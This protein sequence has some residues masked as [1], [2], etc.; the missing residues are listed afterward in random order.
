M[1]LS[2][3]SDPQPPTSHLPP[4]KKISSRSSDELLTFLH[5][6][7]DIYNPPVRG[8]KRRRNSV[9]SQAPNHAND[10]AS[11]PFERTYAIRW[12]TA[13]I[14]QCEI[15]EIFE[16]EST[17]LIIQ[18]A[19]SLL[20]TC[21]G[22]AG[23]GVIRRTFAFSSSV[24]VKLTDVPLEN[25]DFHSVGAQTWGGA[26]VLAEAI[27][28]AGLRILELGAGTGLVSLAAAKM[29]QVWDTPVTIVST[30]FYPTVLANLQ[31]NID[32]NF[33]FSSPV[34]ARFL[35]WATFADDVAEDAMLHQPFDVV[36]GADIVYEAQHA[37]WIKSCLRRLLTPELGI[38]HLVIP[39]RAS[40]SSES[41]TIERDVGIVEKEII[42]CDANE[43]DGG[44][45]VEY[46]YYRIGWV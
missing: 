23:A 8:S 41:S 19:A 14:S 4:I 43:G 21:S 32:A 17:E 42:L 45:T 27:D 31:A 3:L 35:D 28:L 18:E 15:P 29:F 7:R 1:T 34:S 36:L 12:L 22:T 37:V 24:H 5:Y 11:D 20:A 16:P 40:F 10:W 25:S 33:V 30:D 2:T 46:A 39:L 13:L 26:C 6:L 9:H 38:F 44:E